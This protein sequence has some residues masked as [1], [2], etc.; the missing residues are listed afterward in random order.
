[1]MV[2]REDVVREALTWLETPF[3]DCCDKKGVGVDC[4]MLLVRLFCDP[5]VALVPM[6][7]PR[8]YKPQWF[9]H[10]DRSLF[11]EWLERVGARQIE[12]PQPADVALMKFGKHPA[13][14]A[15]VIDDHTILHAYLP[16]KRVILDDRRGLLRCVD[17][18][19]TVFP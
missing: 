5:P 1:M 17:S 18:Y 13:H 7:D 19:W 3:H 10:Q 8:P 15:L 9:L 12:Q 2:T 14:G 6:I 4:A 11:R 16:V